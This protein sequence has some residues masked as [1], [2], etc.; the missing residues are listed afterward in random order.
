MQPTKRTKTLITLALLGILIF[1]SFTE[2]IYPTYIKRAQQELQIDLN[3][4]ENFLIKKKKDQDFIH[5]IRLHFTGK[6]S[7]NIHFLFSNSDSIPVHSIQLKGGEID[8]Y[9]QNDWY[10]DAAIITLESNN[11]QKGALHLE[12]EF[13]D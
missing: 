5:S 9:Y 1:I 12:Y 4:S 2:F 13:F 7:E 10:T 6:S 3:S 11:N 8:Y